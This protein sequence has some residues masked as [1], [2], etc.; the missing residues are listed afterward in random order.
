VVEAVNEDTELADSFPAA[1]DNIR[2]KFEAKNFIT[3]R[4]DQGSKLSLAK[5][6]MV[7]F[8]DG[9]EEK[10]GN[11]SNKTGQTQNPKLLCPNIAE[12]PK[13]GDDSM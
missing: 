9:A 11:F 2:V 12:A 10:V 6:A 1:E 5:S 3:P 8:V 4:N 7:S 13:D